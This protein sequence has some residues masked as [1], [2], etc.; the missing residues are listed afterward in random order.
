MDASARRIGCEQSSEYAATDWRTIVRMR[1]TFAGRLLAGGAVVAGLLAGLALTAAPAGADS[2]LARVTKSSASDST[3]VKR[4]AAV[5]PGGKR[6]VGGGGTVVN[7]GGQVV[8]QQLEPRHT[9]TDDRFVVSAREDQTGFA[10]D[11]TSSQ[12]AA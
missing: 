10:A 3:G 4:V 6:V 8:I 7:G 5:C 1:T 2:G 9:G 12:R 11:P